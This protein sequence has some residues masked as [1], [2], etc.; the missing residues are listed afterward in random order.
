MKSDFLNGKEAVNRAIRRKEEILKDYFSSTSEKLFNEE[1]VSIIQ[2]SA[3]A[4]LMISRF[5]TLENA[6]NICNEKRQ[7]VN[8]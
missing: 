5:I 8:M 1:D 2:Q 3:L 7:M 4:E 6:Y